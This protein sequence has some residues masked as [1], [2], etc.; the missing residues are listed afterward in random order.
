VAAQSKWARNEALLRNRAFVDAY[1][2]ARAAWREGIPA[3]FPPGT[4]CLGRFA[5]MAVAQA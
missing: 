5:Q 3:M 1:T 2:T 4:D